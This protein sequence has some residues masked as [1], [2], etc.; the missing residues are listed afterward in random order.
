M[1]FI[2]T[3]AGVDVLI[4]AYTTLRETLGIDVMAQV[5]AFEMRSHG[6]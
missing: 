3:S 4:I 1:P 5:K 6:R 2:V